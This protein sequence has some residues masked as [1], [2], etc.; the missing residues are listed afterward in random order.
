MIERTPL[1]CADYI[2]KAGRLSSGDTSEQCMWCGGPM[3][4]EHAHYKCTACGQRDSCCDDG[5]MH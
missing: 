5:Q 1:A 4:P 2:A 3:R